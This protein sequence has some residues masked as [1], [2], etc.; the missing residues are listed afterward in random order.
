MSQSLCL[1]YYCGPR[2]LPIGTFALDDTRV[3]DVLL[4]SCPSSC[5]ITND[6]CLVEHSDAVVFHVHDMDINNLP[7]K[8]FSWQKWVFF[9]MESPP[10]TQLE[11]FI[12]AYHMFNWTMTYRRDSDIVSPYSR[13]VP[14]DRN[15]TRRKVDLKALWK[16]KNKT[17][18][19]MV[20]NCYTD[21]AREDFVAELRKHVDVDVYGWCGD[22]DC[23][24]SRGDEC[25]VDFER[26]YFYALSFENSICVDYVT[27]KF[28]NVLKHHVVPVVFGGANY[29]AIAPPHSYINALSFES[30][31]S[32][33]EYLRK[34]SQNYTEYAAYFDWKD[35][36]EVA[37]EDKFCQLC[38]K[39][40][41]P[42]GSSAGFFVRRHRVVVVWQGRRVSEVGV[43]HNALFPLLERW[44]KHW[45][46]R[47]TYSHWLQR[48]S[49][50]NT[51]NQNTDIA[52]A[53]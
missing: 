2:S 29:S 28:F 21:G 42:S 13:V 6:P 1:G 44:K 15:S 40:H 30:P 22:Y 49:A 24:E 19:W 18:V 5:T 31:R 37:W 50:G 14:R 38:T 34:L 17:A 46:W 47:T 3:G 33:A 39:L 45:Q 7:Q 8:R 25:Y 53:L 23:P 12:H 52:H 32:L 48:P 10:N 35:S 20:S 16:S 11:D 51:T 43:R 36:Y 9:L 41:N 4:A 26:T 27:E